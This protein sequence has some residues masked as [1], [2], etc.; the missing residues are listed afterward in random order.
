M[1][2]NKFV[3]EFTA[4]EATAVKQLKS[5]LPDILKAA[6]PETGDAPLN[7]LWGVPLQAESTDERLE[8]ILIKF[9]RARKLDITE[10]RTMLTNTLIWRKKFNADNLLNEQ[11]DETVFAPVGYLHK[12]D[13][14]GRPVTY[15]VYGGKVDLAKVF[16]DKDKFVR[17]RVQLMEIGVAKIDFVNID[18]MIQVHDY[19]GVSI[20]SRNASTKAATREL[21]N[22]MQDNY[23]EM[24]TKK[25]FIN[26]PSWG[27]TIFKLVRPL[28]AEETVKK[29][30]ICSSGES[31][32]ALLEQINPE[33]L[34]KQ[35]GGQSEV[36][37][38]GVQSEKVN[39]PAVPN[40]EP[41]EEDTLGVD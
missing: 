14:F 13:K 1:S 31:K 26:I 18:T 20:F 10:A 24:L 33:N 23:P 2:Q 35:Y 17:W 6:S 38:E 11:F 16:E 19:E 32:A 28:L 7:S 39:N 9:L 21:I 36:H 22:I 15:N 30:V 41:I 37:Q 34:P 27:S 25:F 4:E 40:E 29:F 12:T 5:Q 8:V 3:Q